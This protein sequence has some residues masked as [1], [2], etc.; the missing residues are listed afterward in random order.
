MASLYDLLERCIDW[1]T[2]NAKVQLTGSIPTEYKLFENLQIRDTTEK[3]SAMATLSYRREPNMVLAAYNQHDQAV[4]ITVLNG[5]VNIG[6]Y[7]LIKSITTSLSVPASS[8][9]VKTAV[10]YADL[11]SAFQMAYARVQCTTAPTT[12][13]FD[14]S[15]F[16]I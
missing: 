5:K 1:A 3:I 10:D 16:Q 15:V 6:A 2:G 4:T 12:G 8:F 9:I 14:M 13:R 11:K 7:T